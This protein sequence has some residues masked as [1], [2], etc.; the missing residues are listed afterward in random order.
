ME[1]RLEQW[2]DEV[3]QSGVT[4]R[5]VEIRQQA[6]ELSGDPEFNASS[7]WFYRFTKRRRFFAQQD[8]GSEMV[9][10]M[11][12]TF[13]HDQAEAHDEPMDFVEY[14]VGWFQISYAQSLSNICC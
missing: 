13:E 8:E 1:Q 12:H 7:S 14:E 11:V 5:P 9:P 10:S 6:K 3:E 4:L 2:I